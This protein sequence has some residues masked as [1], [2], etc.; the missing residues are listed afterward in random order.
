MKHLD[1]F[2]GIGGFSLACEWV[3]IET[4]CFVEND[5]YCQ[6]VLRKHWPDVPIVE[7]IRDVEKIKEIVANSTGTRQLRQNELENNNQG[8][9]ARWGCDSSEGSKVSAEV[10]Q[11][12]RRK[13]QSPTLLI[14]AGFPCQPFSVAGK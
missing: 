10:R 12:G 8:K 4:I 6:K 9:R 3:G 14:T 1:L 11:K 13:R 2:S 5:S 7:D